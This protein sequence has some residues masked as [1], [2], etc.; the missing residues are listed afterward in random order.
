MARCNTVSTSH[1]A[2]AFPFVPI[3]A[4]IWHTPLYMWRCRTHVTWPHRQCFRRPH[5]AIYQSLCVH[6]VLWYTCVCVLVICVLVFTVFLYCSAYV[7]L[8]F[9][10]LLFNFVSFV[11]LW[12]CYVFLLLCMFCSV[13]SVSIMPNGTPRLPWLRFFHAFYSV[14]SQMPGYNSQRRG[15][16]RAL[17]KLIVLFF[18]LCVCKCVLYYCHRVS[19]QM[20]LT[21]I[22]IS[23]TLKLRRWYVT[24]V[25]TCAWRAH[26]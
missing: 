23:I 5:S 12:L 16:A 26:T 13:N 21:N 22:S 14:V 18:V 11:F 24:T 17:P 1:N 20:Q 15:T 4:R 19:P 9:F 25:S 10:T 3:N 2:R 7:H 6:C 8:F